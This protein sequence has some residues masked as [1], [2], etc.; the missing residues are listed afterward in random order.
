MLLCFGTTARHK[1]VEKTKK[2]TI[3]AALPLED[4]R[5]PVVFCFNH[6]VGS[7]HLVCQILA[8][9]NNPRRSYCDLTVF[10]FCAVRPVG[11]DGKWS[12]TI[13]R[14]LWTHNASVQHNRTLGTAEF[15]M[16]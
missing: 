5:P 7:A 15:L 1:R 2:V 14:S 13:R 10:N 8:H 12:L 11:F 3:S 16:I 9:S 4:A 6:E